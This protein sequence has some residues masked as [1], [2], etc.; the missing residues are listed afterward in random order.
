VS[1]GRSVDMLTSWTSSHAFC[2]FPF[3]AAAIPWSEARKHIIVV[4]LHPARSLPPP[5]RRLPPPAPP[6]FAIALLYSTLRPSGLAGQSVHS[7]METC[8]LTRADYRREASRGKGEPFF[9]D[10]SWHFFRPVLYFACD[11]THIH[12]HQRLCRNMRRTG[13]AL[14]TWSLVM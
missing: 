12:T 14:A 11:C 3:V 4:R 2:F 1:R 6:S 13:T 9:S 7:R 5:L 8:S 10:T